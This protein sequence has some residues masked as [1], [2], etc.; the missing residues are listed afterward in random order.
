MEPS[1]R[2]SSVR[3]GPVLDC[4]KIERE[5]VRSATMDRPTVRVKAYQRSGTDATKVAQYEVLGNDAKKMSVPARTIE[6]SVLHLSHAASRANAA[7]AVDRPVRDGSPFLN[8]N[9]ALRT[10]LLSSGPSGTQPET[11]SARLWPLTGPHGQ[12]FR[13]L[14]LLHLLK[15]EGCDAKIFSKFQ[16]V[17]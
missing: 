13:P 9:P 3:R 17:A 1:L 14:S 6:R 8:A 5:R 2:G 11:L 7:T 10:G 16:Q 4:W 15:S 12:R